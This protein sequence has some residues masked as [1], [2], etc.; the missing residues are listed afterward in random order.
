MMNRL[1][2]SELHDFLLNYG[3]DLNELVGSQTL[4]NE[5][6]HRVDHYP[7]FAVLDEPIRRQF[8]LTCARSI[9]WRK[10]S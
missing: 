5:L 6:L 9:N 2:L 10:Q 8:R 1:C 4:M 7:L 3:S